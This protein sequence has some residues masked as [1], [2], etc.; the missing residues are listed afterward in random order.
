MQLYAITNSQR[1]ATSLSSRI[2][3]LCRLAAGWA[4]GGVEYLQIREKDLSSGELELLT[5][6]VIKEIKRSQTQVLV[7]GRADVAL[8]AE[9]DGVHLPGG[10]Q[11]S[12]AEIGSLYARTGKSEPAISVACHSLAEAEAAKDAGATLIVFAPVFEKPTSE[13]PLPGKG[14]DM[15]SAVCQTVSPLP[16]FALGGVGLEN[17][18]KCAAVGAS[19]I[20]AIRLFAS[21]DWRSLRR[22]R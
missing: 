7:N 19:G 1:A 6:S 14:L 3:A 22:E 15:L 16:V 4:R 10:L 8:S 21:D 17:A 18:E 2:E 5:A 12:P 11:L 20:A 9:A 13:G